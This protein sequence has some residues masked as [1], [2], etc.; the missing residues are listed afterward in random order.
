ME[1]LVIAK[2]AV[3]LHSQNLGQWVIHRLVTGGQFEGHLQAIRDVYGKQCGVMIEAIEKYLPRE[4][5]TTRP[6]GGMFIWV[7]LPPDVLAMD[8]F[9]RAI[10]KGV[11]FVPGRPFFANGGGEHSMR[12]NFS[13]SDEARIVEEHPQTCGGDG[14]NAAV[15]DQLC[16]GRVRFSWW[17]GDADVCFTELLFVD[18]A[19]RA[20]HQ[21]GAA[22]GFWESNHVAD[23]GD[24]A[25]D[26]DEAIEA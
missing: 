10:R 14:A 15:I 18:R 9:E 7:T 4:V 1:K 26:H 11:A 17:K 20:A 16:F 24:A 6:E 2:Q 23:V 5:R 12:L 3:D 8:L 25:K 13:N 19:G 21:I 22:L